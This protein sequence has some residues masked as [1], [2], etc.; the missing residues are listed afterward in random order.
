[1]KAPKLLVGN[2]TGHHDQYS[3][4]FTDGD[5]F[6]LRGRGSLRKARE[7]A[8]LLRR[9]AQATNTHFDVSIPGGENETTV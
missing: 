9:G 1:M 8:H 4:T 5:G 6:I 2:P 7:L 3:I